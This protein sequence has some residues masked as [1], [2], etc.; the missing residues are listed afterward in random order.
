MHTLPGEHDSCRRLCMFCLRLYYL[1]GPNYYPIQLL[2]TL[3]DDG[4]EP[5]EWIRE[6]FYQEAKKGLEAEEGRV[7]LAL[8]ATLGVQWT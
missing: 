6:Q 1:I 7:S 2:D 4:S 8:V 5:N 3:T